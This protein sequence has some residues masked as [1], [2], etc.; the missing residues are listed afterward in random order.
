MGVALCPAGVKE[1]DGAGDNAAD[2]DPDNE[3]ELSVG[4]LNLTGEADSRNL[5]LL[6]DPTGERHGEDSEDPTGERHGAE[7]GGSA[8]RYAVSFDPFEELEEGDRVFFPFR[9][10]RDLMG[11]FSLNTA[12]ARGHAEWL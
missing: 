3:P 2:G 11:E 9:E 6:T 4:D 10:D 8:A 12:E 7:V 5:P 1:K